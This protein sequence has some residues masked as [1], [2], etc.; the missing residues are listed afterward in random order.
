MYPVVPGHEVVG[1][2]TEVGAGVTTVTV[3][4][5][6]AVGCIKDCCLKC[7]ACTD[8]E[9]PYCSRG[10]TLLFNSHKAKVGESGYLGYLYFDRTVFKFSL[11]TFCQ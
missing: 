3:G 7:A 2:V 10:F 6:V 4:D 1:K 8:G 9:E 11:D 5:H